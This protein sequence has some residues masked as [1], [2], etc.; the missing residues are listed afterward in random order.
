[1]VVRSEAEQSTREVQR[2]REELE[3]RSHELQTKMAGLLERE[4]WIAN[5]C[6]VLCQQSENHY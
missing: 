2:L 6:D 5:V 4:S 1:M 3:E